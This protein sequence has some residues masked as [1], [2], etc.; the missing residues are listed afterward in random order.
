M[1]GVLIS[2]KNQ[3]FLAILEGL[4]M[5]VVCFFGSAVF[6]SNLDTAARC[7][8]VMDVVIFRVLSTLFF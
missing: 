7:V 8:G 1:S 6:L 2:L 5:H 4:S 3:R